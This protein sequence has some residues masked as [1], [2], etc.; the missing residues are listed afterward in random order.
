MV[1]VAT[2]KKGRPVDLPGEGFHGLAFDELGRPHVLTDRS[3]FFRQEGS[4]WVGLTPG[5]PGTP[6]GPPSSCGIGWL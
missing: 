6:V 1:S 4:T 5:W 3:G 2:D